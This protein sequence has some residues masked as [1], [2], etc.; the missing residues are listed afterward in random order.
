VRYTLA[1]LHGH[2][3]NCHLKSS[4]KSCGSSAFQ[5]SLHT[6]GISY[7][8]SARCSNFTCFCRVQCQSNNLPCVG[9][10]HI[11]LQAVQLGLSCPEAQMTFVYRSS[12]VLC[13]ATKLPLLVWGQ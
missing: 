6:H 12:L 7:M 11:N 9:S 4:S 8:C 13:C 5:Y 10:D 1:A 2:H 3:Y